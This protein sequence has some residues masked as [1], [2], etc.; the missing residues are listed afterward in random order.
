MTRRIERV[1]KN[2]QRILG[3]IIQEELRPPGMVSVMDVTCDTR[4]TTARVAVSVYA[5]DSEPRATIEYL[6]R[7][8]AF[9][10]RELSARAQMR[11]TPKIEFV[12]DTSL[13]DGQS[14]IDLIS[15]VSSS[16]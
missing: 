12:L 15:D 3:E 5:S 11:R 6:E 4:L 2:V 10:R 9:I 16:R 13:Q 8:I 7:R 14:M 1:E